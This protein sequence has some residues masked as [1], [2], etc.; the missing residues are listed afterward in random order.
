MLKNNIGQ[1]CKSGGKLHCFLLDSSGYVV[2][3][4]SFK[5][6]YNDS[7]KVLNKHITETDAEIARDLIKNGLMVRRKCQNFN[8]LKLQ[9][10][11]EITMN[12]DIHRGSIITKKPRCKSYAMVKVSGTNLFVDICTLQENEACECPCKSRLEYNFCNASLTGG[13][14]AH[15]LH[16]QFPR[17][18]H[19]RQHPDDLGKCFNVH[20]GD[21]K[22]EQTCNEIFG[23]F[24]CYKMTDGRLLKSPSC[25][26]D[27]KCYGGVL[28]R[29]IPFL[30]PHKHERKAKDRKMFKIL[31]GRPNM[32]REEMDFE[33]MEMF[34]VE[35][36]PQMMDTTDML[37]VDQG[38]G[39]MQLNYPGQSTA[40]QS[41]MQMRLGGP[42]M[43]GYST[44]A[45]SGMW[46]K[47]YGPSRLMSF[48]PQVS[49]M[50]TPGAYARKPPGKKSRRKKPRKVSFSEELREGAEEGPIAVPEDD[51]I[52]TEDT[53]V[54]EDPKL[55]K[56]RAIFEAATYFNRNVLNFPFLI[57]FLAYFFSFQ[58][59]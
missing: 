6:V 32:A 19:F 5:N 52:V 55:P 54:T 33:A 21:Y 36:Q 20:C 39:A 50:Q 9:R 42:G 38:F 34:A 29:E 57:R 24:W 12:K 13:S 23:F 18:R 46:S 22:E 30:L 47:A 4:P 45:M 58:S 40:M 3:H 1:S 25:K 28:G 15:N 49:T 59:C 41:N 43:H 37:N 53:K 17:V 2:Y 8:L 35:D 10:F 26:S 7:T 56:R 48:V 16:H 11:Y 27:R 44:Q 31:G 14:V 51:P